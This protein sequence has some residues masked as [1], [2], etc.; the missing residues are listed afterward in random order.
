MSDKTTTDPTPHF[1]LRARAE[2]H[3]RAA[4]DALHVGDYDEALA[5]I[6]RAGAAVTELQERANVE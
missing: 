5:W 4:E 2:S 6:S 1:R 3:L